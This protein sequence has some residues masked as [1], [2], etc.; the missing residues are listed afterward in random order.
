MKASWDICCSVVDNYGDAAVTWRLARQLAAEHG[1]PVRLWIDDLAALVRLR[2][3]AA[4]QA[5]P[6]C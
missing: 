3:G 2:P 1:R 4:P 6:Q 5:R